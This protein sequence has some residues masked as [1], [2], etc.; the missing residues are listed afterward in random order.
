MILPEIEGLGGLFFL[1]AK[2]R[3]RDLDEA[4]HCFVSLAAEFR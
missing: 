3:P 4:M 2:D 1:L